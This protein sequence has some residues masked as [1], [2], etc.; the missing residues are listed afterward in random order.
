[1]AKGRKGNKKS[2]T[3]GKKSGSSQYKGLF[4]F[5]PR[6]FSIG[7]NVQPPIDLTRFVKWPKYVTLQRQKRVLLK[8]LKVPPVIHQLSAALD[9]NQQK[10]LFKLL[11]KYAPE[12]KEEKQARLKQLA[13]EKRED[14]KNVGSKPNLLKFGLNQVTSLVEN[15]LAQ[16]VIIAADVDP[17]EL[18][19]WLPALCRAK[20]VPFCIVKSQSVLGKFVGLKKTTT[21]AITSVDKSDEHS[22]TQLKEKFNNQFNENVEIAKKYGNKVMGIKFTHKEDAAKRAKDRELLKKGK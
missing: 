6:N 7:N 18:V 20:E 15:N 5:T 3:K 1:M 2:T 22:L 14:K 13:K 17:V 10:T 8:R 21:I 16:L 12:K 9:A 19:C 4:E 11:A